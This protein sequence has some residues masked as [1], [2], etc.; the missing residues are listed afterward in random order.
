MPGKLRLILSILAYIAVYGLAVFLFIK[1]AGWLLQ[2]IDPGALD[3]G[4][5]A[6]LAALVG[7]RTLNKTR[8]ER[9]AGANTN[10]LSWLGFILAVLLLIGLYPLAHALGNTQKIG[11]AVLLF[12]FIL[13]SVTSWP[14]PGLDYG[15]DDDYY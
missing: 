13:I 10:L 9:Q 15:N 1:A 3:V 11:L 14:P 2:F 7:I 4:C 12:I 5:G 6:V 8:Q